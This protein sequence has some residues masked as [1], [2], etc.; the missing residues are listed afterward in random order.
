MA[1]QCNAGPCYRNF[2]IVTVKSKG[3][4]STWECC[5][6]IVVGK[7]IGKSQFETEKGDNKNLNRL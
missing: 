5:L 4:T 3:T 1:S 6:R 2:N 7:L